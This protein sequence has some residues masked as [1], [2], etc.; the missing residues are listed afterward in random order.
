MTAGVSNPTLFPTGNPT[1]NPTALTPT[2]VDQLAALSGTLYGLQ[3]TQISATGQANAAAESV[4]GANAE[5]S[6]YGTA[7]AIS[8]ENQAIAGIAGQISLY[9]QQRQV[10]QTVGQ[11]QAAAGAGG[12]I[13]GGSV[14]DVMAS[15]Y[16]QGAIGSQL[17]QVQTAL[18][19]GGYAE[20]AAATQA[21]VAAANAQA[22]AAQQEGAAFSAEATQAAAE[23]AQLQTLYPT[24]TQTLGDLANNPT[25][26]VTPSSQSYTS[27]LSGGGTNTAFHY[28]FGN[29][30]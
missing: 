2:N 5:A 12:A 8:T 6:A 9:Q 24:Q 26:A 20:Q 11:E 13:S 3:A 30:G 21:E 28:N 15:S 14:Y 29:L 16:N 17:I 1:T 27:Y 10:A 4:T 18:D 19:Q 7:G 23:A 22:A 25:S